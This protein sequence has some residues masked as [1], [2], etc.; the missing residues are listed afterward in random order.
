M[1]WNNFARGD[2]I[3]ASFYGYGVFRP[4]SGSEHYD[5]IYEILRNSG[6][7]VL[8]VGANEGGIS[9]FCAALGHRVHAIEAL[10]VN[11]RTL[12]ALACA[13]GFEDK[14]VLHPF[15]ASNVSGDVIC[16][17]GSGTN[18]VRMSRHIW[19]WTSYA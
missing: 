1:K 7:A 15:A 10:P 13:N 4:V 17:R 8:D 3:L 2:R 19:P 6:G 12:R 16:F 11:Q 5:L 18:P 9:A 14:L